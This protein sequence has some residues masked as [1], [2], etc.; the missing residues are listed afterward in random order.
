MGGGGVIIK[1]KVVFAIVFAVFILY[2]AVSSFYA[3]VHG[4]EKI[5]VV[6]AAWLEAGEDINQEHPVLVKAVFYEMLPW[7][8]RQDLRAVNGGNISNIYTMAFDTPAEAKVVK[9]GV[10]RIR[11]VSGVIISLLLIGIF[12]FT[13]RGFI[14]LSLILASG[15]LFS[16]MLDGW[17]YAIFMVA[18]ESLRRN[19]AFGFIFAFALLPL[20]KIYGFVLSLLLAV[21]F[22]RSNYQQF[23][24]S[25]LLIVGVMVFA[26]DLHHLLFASGWYLSGGGGAQLRYSVPFLSFII[27]TI[28][29]K[30]GGNSGKAEGIEG[31]ASEKKA[32]AKG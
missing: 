17:V 27:L 1:Q 13:L 2:G 12:G 18:Y 24:K 23:L 4:D 25:V 30:K 14:V 22:Y 20:S 8:M 28:I 21:W 26:Y 6:A 29:D 7:R 5:Y 16:A 3:P 11:L 9:E 32:G 19:K 15:G 31:Q 10:G